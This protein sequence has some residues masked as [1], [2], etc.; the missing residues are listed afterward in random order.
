[1]R[2]PWPYRLL[3]WSIALALFVFSWLLRFNDPGGSFAGLTD[4]LE[5]FERDQLARDDE[6]DD[7]RAEVTVL[8]LSRTRA[9]LTQHDA[10]GATFDESPSDESLA[11]LTL[12]EEAVR[13]AFALDTADRNDPAVIRGAEPWWIVGV[14]R[15]AT[16]TQ[17][18]DP[19]PRYLVH[20]G[21]A[22]PDEYETFDA[23]LEAYMRTGRTGRLWRND[24]GDAGDHL[25]GLSVAERAAVEVMGRNES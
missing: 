9:A 22:T 23:A 11:A 7:D 3:V 1:M 13:D 17:A 10:A 20:V 19:E 5:T 4:D 14:A 12:A 6:G 8:D 25:D 2:T 16:E 15:R 18:H 24:D 21:N